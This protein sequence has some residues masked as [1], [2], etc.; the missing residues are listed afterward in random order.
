MQGNADRELSDRLS[1]ADQI[2]IYVV[3]LVLNLKL[4]LYHQIS[5]DISPLEVEK[6]YIINAH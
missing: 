2:F 5:V 4:N 1:N 3:I 6:H